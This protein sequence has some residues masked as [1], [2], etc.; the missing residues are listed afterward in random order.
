[1]EL[2]VTC[3]TLLTDALGAKDSATKDAAALLQ[4]IT[5]EAKHSVRPSYK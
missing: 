4:I 5:A 3:V 2:A 1:M